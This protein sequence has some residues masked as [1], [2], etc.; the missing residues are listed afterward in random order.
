M[1]AEEHSLLLGTFTTPG[2]QNYLMV[3]GVNLPKM[4][5]DGSS[6]GNAVV[7][8][9]DGGAV[10]GSSKSGGVTVIPA[11]HYDEE[12]SEIGGFGFSGTL[13]SKT[14]APP[15]PVDGKIEIKM[16]LLHEGEVNRAR[17]CPKNHFLVATK[18]PSP[19]VYIFDLSKHPSFPKEDE[20]EFC[21]QF[22]LGGHDS[23][24]YGLAWNPHK[25]GEI[26]S[27]SE[28]KKVCL[29][30]INNPPKSSSNKKGESSTEHL[31]IDPLTTFLGHEDV[32]EDVDWH[33]LDPNL[34]GSCG[35]DGHIMLWDVRQRGTINGA[36]HVI[37]NAHEKDIHCIEFH[38]TNE[39]LLASGSVDKTVALWDMR[40]LKSR[41]QTLTGHTD[42]IL[43]V[44]WSPF[45]ES[46]LAS[47]SADRRVNIWDLS[48]IGMEQSPEDAQD[49]P[50]ELLFMHGGHTS[51]VSDFHWN[52]N[53]PWTISSVSED[54]V[55][56][57][58][59][60]AEEIYA[61]DDDEEDEDA[62]EEG[63][64]EVE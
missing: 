11:A 14:S 55:L 48:R 47:C 19:Y 24:G 22:V 4:S 64:M 9:N 58:W 35:D 10:D 32:I 3:C 43:Q 17:Y 50:P 37:R 16:K 52:A 25:E 31:T 45:N 49:G 5:E 39:F 46:I 60:M 13:T 56:Q 29:W 59:T 62:E 8:S 42:Q 54:N 51:K 21:P 41:I 20:A 12:K 6:D 2:E 26:C 30:D 38:P 27:G 33:K 23:E 63:D 34:I 1:G 61:E 36:A 53:D 44:S 18:G 28:D 40:N 15:H 7:P 57:V